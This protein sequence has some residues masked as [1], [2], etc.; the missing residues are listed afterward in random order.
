MRIP[1]QLVGRKFPSAKNQT[2]GELAIG[3]LQ[4]RRLI[5]HYEKINEFAGVREYVSLE[6]GLP[7]CPFR[8]SAEKLFEHLIIEFFQRVGIVGKLPATTG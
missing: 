7:A 6:H 2:R 8:Q 1:H 4:F 5:R 3:D